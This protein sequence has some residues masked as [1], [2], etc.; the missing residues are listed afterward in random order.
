MKK[1]YSAPAAYT[2]ELQMDENIASSASLIIGSWSF[3]VE[4][5]GH[6]YEYVNMGVGSLYPGITTATALKAAGFSPTK[7]YNRLLGQYGEDQADII[8]A[9]CSDG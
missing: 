1:E 5:D 3:T 2:I 8:W 4:V 7:Y 6:C 9:V